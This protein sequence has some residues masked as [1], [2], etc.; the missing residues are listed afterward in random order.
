MQETVPGV[1]TPVITEKAY[2][3]EIFK[4]S[5]LLQSSNTVNNSINISNQISVVADPYLDGHIHDMQYAEFKGTKWEI[6]SVDASQRPRLT[7]T[8]GGLY[9]EH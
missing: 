1:Y 4:S 7:I 8:L 2:R 6:S 5:R 9:N 3:G